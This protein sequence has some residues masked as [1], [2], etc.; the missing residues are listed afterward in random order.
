LPLLVAPTD[1]PPIR[2]KSLRS[3]ASFK[4]TELAT[5]RGGFWGR[6]GR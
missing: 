1:R 5:V 4:P 6:K 2:L 3:P